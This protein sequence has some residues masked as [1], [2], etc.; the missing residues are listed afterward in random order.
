MSQEN[1]EIVRAA[2][3]AWN[4]GEMDAVREAHHP[5]AMIVRGLE[6]WPEGSVATVGREAIM[7]LWEQLREAWDVDTLEPVKFIDAGD[8][9]VAR[10]IW[11]G[12]G[13]GPEARMEFSQVFTLRKGKV[14]L[15][16]YFWNHAE[17]LEAVGLSEQDAHA[18]S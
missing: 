5:D 7:R 11:H 14:F 15:S 18:D 6:G 17:A 8:R 4:A 9:V 12:A 1:V 16:E 13:H 3:D 10:L 2:F